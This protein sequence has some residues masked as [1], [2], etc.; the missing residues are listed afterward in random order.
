MDPRRPSIRRLLYDPPAAER[1]PL[2]ACKGHMVDPLRYYDLEGY[3]LGEV[4]GRFRSQGYISAFEFFSI[5][6]WKAN[7]AKS[8]IARRLIKVDPKGRTALEPIVRD[9]TSSL[10][11]ATDERSRLRFLVE[12]WGFGLPMATAILAILWPDDFTVYDVRVC[13]QLGAFRELAHFTRFDRVWEGYL[14]YRAAVVAATPDQNTLR[15]KDRFLWAQSAAIQ[16]EKD[17]ACGFANGS[18]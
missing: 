17:I 16:L 5:V 13:E 1:Y 10:A 2:G 4:Q 7:R 12:T 18:A 15:N 8:H 3:L 11:K 9:L 14:K 6:I